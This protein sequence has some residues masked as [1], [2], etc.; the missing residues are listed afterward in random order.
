M[1]AAALLAT[2]ACT[3]SKGS[4]GSSSQPAAVPLMD[5]PRWEY[6]ADFLS[7]NA[8]PDADMHPAVDKLPGALLLDATL[9]RA[10]AVR[11]CGDPAHGLLRLVNMAAWLCDA[12]R[13]QLHICTACE[14]SDSMGAPMVE[15]RPETCA[16]LN[17]L[18]TA[19]ALLVPYGCAKAVDRHASTGTSG[20]EQQMP[21]TAPTSSRISFAKMRRSTSCTFRLARRMSS[22]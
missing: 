14:A 2:A 12:P 16:A 21:G 10:H 19:S 9:L 8:L 5:W 6:A 7:V 22:F 15:R 18:Q 13:I 17:K 3:T 20:V 1:M 4:R 11:A